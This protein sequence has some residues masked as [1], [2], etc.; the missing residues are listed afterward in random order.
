MP[1][2]PTTPVP[3]APVPVPMTISPVPAVPEPPMTMLPAAPEAEAP[4]EPVSGLTPVPAAEEPVGEP[5]PALPDPVKDAGGRTSPEQ[6]ATATRPRMLA[7]K[8]MGMMRAADMVAPPGMVAGLHWRRR[9]ERFG[10]GA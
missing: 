1:I 9:C 6:A 5:L 2:T 7:R 8:A 4:A 10:S 3:P